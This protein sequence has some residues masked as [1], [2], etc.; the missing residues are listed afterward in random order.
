[1]VWLLEGRDTGA[2]NYAGYDGVRHRQYTTSERTA[3]LFKR[4][5]RIQFSDSGH[6]IVFTARPHSG[7]RMP[8][9]R[10]EYVAEQMARLRAEDR[11]GS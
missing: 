11:R 10:M 2:H 7:A 9:R 4:I 1:M 6:G 8:V 3:D 5:P